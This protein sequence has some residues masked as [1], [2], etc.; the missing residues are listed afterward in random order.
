M[1]KHCFMPCSNNRK[2]KSEASLPASG[3]KLDQSIDQAIKQLKT[4][5]TRRDFSPN[6]W[7]DH[8]KLWRELLNQSK[9]RSL[10]REVSPNLLKGDLASPTG[11]KLDGRHWQAFR[12]WFATNVAPELL[13]LS[14]DSGVPALQAIRRSNSKGGFPEKSE[15]VFYLAFYEGE[16]NTN[17]DEVSSQTDETSDLWQ[18]FKRYFPKRSCISDNLTAIE[19]RW[20]FGL[21][22]ALLGIFLLFFC[23]FLPADN[24]RGIFIS[25]SV[26]LFIFGLWDMDAS[27][28]GDSR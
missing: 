7:P 5:A 6:S 11:I 23:I 18:K 19:Q 27:N 2:S 21:S 20:R 13:L 16:K 25:F 12:K 3:P 9:S 4:L 17:D 26:I 24:R 1:K 8:A 15:S 10:N 28:K 22:M 14:A